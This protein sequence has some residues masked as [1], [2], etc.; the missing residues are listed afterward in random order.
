[1]TPE[2]LKRKTTAELKKEYKSTKV[3]LKGLILF[4]IVLISYA[5]YGL[6]KKGDNVVFFSILFVGIF[7]LSTLPYQI[8]FMKKIKEEIKKRHSLK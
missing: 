2:Y 8:K 3:V 6:L 7:C 4:L 5:I 1:M